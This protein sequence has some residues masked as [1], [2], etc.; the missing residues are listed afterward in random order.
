MFS[1]SGTGQLHCKKTGKI[2]DVELK[3]QPVNGRTRIHC[4]PIQTEDPYA[5]QTLAFNSELLSLQNVCLRSAAGN[6][7]ADI[8]TEV[9]LSYRM[10][11]TDESPLLVTQLT[12]PP[13]KQHSLNFEAGY[14]ITKSTG[15]HFQLDTRQS[16]K[17]YQLMFVG[18]PQNMKSFNTELV[19]NNRRIRISSYGS[20]HPSL[21]GIIV[22]IKQQFVC[23]FKFIL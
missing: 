19:L 18:T 1:L 10:S 13:D 15:L 20:T 7:T 14:L 22:A 17:G 21:A 23:N 12:H 3:I 9:H 11:S 4:I 5:F 8:L 16:V 2:L 6:L